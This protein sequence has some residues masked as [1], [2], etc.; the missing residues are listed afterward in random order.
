L[1]LVQEPSRFTCSFK[2]SSG[3]RRYE[4]LAVYDVELSAPVWDVALQL[5]G[6][7]SFQILAMIA[8][9][10]PAFDRNIMRD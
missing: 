6:R 8:L 9:V 4:W 3:F 7:S 1:L 2:Q 5:E 10:I